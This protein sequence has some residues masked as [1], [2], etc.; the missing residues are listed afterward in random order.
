MKGLMFAIHSVKIDAVHAIQQAA[1][2]RQAF[3]LIHT[4]AE[5]EVTVSKRPTQSDQRSSEA[6]A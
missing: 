2:S 6:R 4:P 5:T 1:S 3:A